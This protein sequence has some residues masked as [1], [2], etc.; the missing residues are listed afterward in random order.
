MDISQFID[1]FSDCVYL[2]SCESDKKVIYPDVRTDKGKELFYFF[3]LLE[4]KDNNIFFNPYTKQV[5]EC[6][7]KRINLDNKEY[8][9]TRFLDITKYKK[10]ENEY[11]LDETTGLFLRK[12]LLKSLNDYLI[13]ASRNEE[14]FSL[15]MLD[16]DSFKK[17]ND[18]YGHQYGD[19]CL[20]YLSK[21]LHNRV[22]NNPEKNGILG[23]FGGEEFIF[24][25]NNTDYEYSKY[26]NELIREDIQKEMKNVEGI[27]VN[28]TCSFGAVFVDKNVFRYINT[29]NMPEVRN[30]IDSIIKQ[31][32][33]NL[34]ESKKTGKNKLTF[35]RYEK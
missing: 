1:C 24:T 22:N 21:I 5:F 10:I 14:S 12:K 8:T 2:I 29:T 4:K 34:Y 32:D 16:I 28:L 25:I 19:V 9:I 30:K 27:D 13:T 15:T 33:R 31:A 11:I 23:R 17:I 3:S 18:N 20:N 7:E 35:T 26:R 6:V